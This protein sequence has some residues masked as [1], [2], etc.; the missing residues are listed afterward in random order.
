[1]KKILD[2][3]LASMICIS[4][5]CI[6]FCLGLLTNPHSFDHAAMIAS[7]AD[8]TWKMSTDGNHILWREDP[9]H[10]GSGWLY[11]IEANGDTVEHGAYASGGP[12]PA[13]S[14]GWDT[15]K[16]PYRFP[17]LFQMIDVPSAQGAHNSTADSLIKRIDFLEYAVRSSMQRRDFLDSFYWYGSKRIE[18]LEGQISLLQ[19]QIKRQ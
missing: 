9:S 12:G 13:I 1:M 4:V 15:V 8:S 2:I 3:L 17:V 11:S 19:N 10:P 6:I 18:Y 14:T 5:L 7:P 16:H